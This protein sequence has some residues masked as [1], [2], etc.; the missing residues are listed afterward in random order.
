MADEAAATLPLTP[1]TE[2]PP[3]G[4]LGGLAA[5][6]EALNRLTQQ[7]KI[8]AIVGVA[9]IVA[10]IVGAWLWTHEA[11]YSVLMTIEDQKDGAQVVE[12][13]TQQQVPFKYSDDGRKILVPQ[14]QVHDARMKL[15]LQGYKKLGRIGY[16][17]IDKEKLGTSDEVR[18][19]NFQ[20]ALEGELEQTLRSLVGVH[21]SRV[22]LAIPKQSAFLDPDR[23]PTASVVL[24]LKPGYTLEPEQVNG[25]INLISSSVSKLDPKDVRI[26]DQSGMPLSTQ[27]REV[28]REGD[29]NPKQYE[30]IR[31]TEAKLT[32]QLESVLAPTLGANNVR[33]TVTAD[34]DFTQ[35]EQVDEDYKLNPPPETAIR[36]QQS[37]ETLYQTPNVQGVPGA[38]TNQPPI[39][40]TA[41]ITTPPVPGTPGAAPNALSSTQTVLKSDTKNFE[42]SKTYR[43]TKV[44]P[45]I[46]RLT[47]AVAVNYKMEEEKKTG[48]LRPV[49]LSDEQI[50]RIRELTEG[51]I[52][53]SK[54]RGDSVSVANLEFSPVVKEDADRPLWKDPEVVS[55]AVSA[56]KD[57]PKILL[58]G[59]LV[60][61]LWLKLIKPALD[62]I[63][64][65]P[66]PEPEGPTPEELA[67]AEA[68]AEAE[69]AAKAAE[70]EESEMGDDNV[71]F[72]ADGLA[73]HVQLLPHQIFEQKLAE[74]RELTR[75]DP[76]AVAN[77]I[78][79]W[80]GGEA[81]AGR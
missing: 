78:K 49:P 70:E 42:P 69:A 1:E 73:K 47:A 13:L 3:P 24:T 23:K 65:P 74:A 55:F 36:S 53:F 34:I 60:F 18:N 75:K 9:L 7:Q 26:T 68:Q 66:P 8:A 35:V 41:P 50:N 63:F 14:G 39:P 51:A 10:L 6:K 58:I 62:T 37:T 2:A 22:H 48:K 27:P 46:K 21:N 12:A 31:E 76:K 33:A 64:P 80:M 5:L 38:L 79:E 16:E 61:F 28:V 54:E 32:K 72:G 19:K 52:G 45:K 67:A 77:M 4:T 43:H 29:P 44:V 56:G 71:E 30:L 15:A 11:P 25:V 17:L 20:R 40:P 59:A 57:L 81:A